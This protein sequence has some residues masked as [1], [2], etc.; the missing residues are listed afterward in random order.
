MKNL[1]AT[2]RRFL[3]HL[4]G[5]GLGGTLLPGVLWASMQQSGAE[6]I[7]MPMLQS[8]LALSGLKFTDE[9]EKAMLSSVNQSLTRYE[10]FRKIQIPNDVSPPF[11]FSALVPGMTI[12]RTKQPFHM[13][14]PSVKRPANLEDVAFW[15]VVQLSQL[16]KTRQVTSTELTEMYLARL[17]KYNPKLNCAVTDRKSVV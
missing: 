4:S 10:T 12:N 15:P 2:R 17:R 5:I 11:H 7:S 1:E 13:S 8:A 6:Q 9:D 16:I 3:A 14:A